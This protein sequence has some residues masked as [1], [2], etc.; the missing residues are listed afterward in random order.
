[1]KAARED[2]LE[3]HDKSGGFP[4]KKLV[5]ALAIIVVGYTLW[6][7]FQQQPLEP[8][9]EPVAVEDIVIAETVLPAAEDIPPRPEPVVEP[10]AEMP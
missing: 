3:S 6:Q 8:M 2:R 7:S 4:I 1:M 10:A 9:P 5:L